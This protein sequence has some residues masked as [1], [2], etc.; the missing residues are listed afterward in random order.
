[1]DESDIRGLDELGN[2]IEA[3]RCLGLVQSRKAFGQYGAD[4]AASE[5]GLHASIS[6][7]SAR[8]R[9]EVEALRAAPQQAEPVAWMKFGGSVIHTMLKRGRPELYPEHTIPLYLHPPA[10]EVQRLRDVLQS[11]IEV[12]DQ[13]ADSQYG[14]P[15]ARSVRDIARRALEG[16]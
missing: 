11:L 1:M 3:A 6:E 2:L 4:D 14:T 8:L 9:A 15:F 12:A 10:D 16:E 7:R 5:H 13:S